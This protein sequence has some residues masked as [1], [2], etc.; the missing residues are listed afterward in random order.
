ME[1]KSSPKGYKPG[2]EEISDSLANESFS[3]PNLVLRLCAQIL[4]KN[5]L[6]MAARITQLWLPSPLWII[7]SNFYMTSWFLFVP[8]IHQSVHSQ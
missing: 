7:D 1:I 6:L 4:T 8:L 2:M 3:H 5:Q